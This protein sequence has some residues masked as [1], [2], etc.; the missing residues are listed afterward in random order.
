MDLVLTP[1][2][3]AAQDRYYGRHQVSDTGRDSDALGAGEVEMIES[4]DSFYMATVNEH[5]WPY[6]QHRGGPAGFLRVVAG[7]QIGFADFGGNRQLLS[8]GNLA[9]NDRVALFLMDYPSRSRL[10]LLGRARV[11]AAKDAGHALRQRF[12]ASTGRPV[13]RIFLID[14]VGFNW[15]CPQ[16]ITPRFTA[17]QI[18]H[19][20]EPMKARI[21]ELEAQLEEARTAMNS[22]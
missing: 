19:R 12:M 15:N 4:R 18:A 21:A 17:E 3:Q 10:K 6:I 2:V 8:T 20:I 9:G 14:V 5:G 1:S 13:E 7:N 11:V 16:H 22:G